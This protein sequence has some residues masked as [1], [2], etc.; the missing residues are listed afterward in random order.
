MAGEHLLEGIFKSGE[1]GSLRIGEADNVGSQ[2]AGG[3]DPTGCRQH[4]DARQFQGDDL[5]GELRRRRAHQ[6]DERRRLAEQVLDGRSA[7]SDQRGELL[8]FGRGVGDLARVR[9]DITRIDRLSQGLAVAIDDDAA[10]RRQGDRVQPLLLGQ[11]RIGRAVQALQ[12]HEPAADQG[13]HDQ[14]ADEQPLDPAP[15]QCHLPRAR[16]GTRSSGWHASSVPG[17]RRVGWVT[18]RGPVPDLW[19]VPLR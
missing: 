15:R 5:R 10:R 1:A 11:R 13:Q 16:A 19:C 14:T 18:R 9:I 12:L 3:V 7:Q 17:H 2:R 4:A 6:V 8:R